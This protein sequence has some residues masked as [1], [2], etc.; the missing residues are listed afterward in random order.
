LNDD[1][2]TRLSAAA[3]VGHGFPNQLGDVDLV[4]RRHRRN[5]SGQPR[6]ALKMITM[7][8]GVF[9]AVA[10]SDALLTAPG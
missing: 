4:L 6:A 5:R 9:G 2:R 8:G 7:Q 1:L 10:T 3:S